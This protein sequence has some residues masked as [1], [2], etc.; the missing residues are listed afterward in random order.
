VTGAS[1]GWRREVKP[2]G[3]EDARFCFSTLLCAFVV[4]NLPRS[5]ADEFVAWLSPEKALKISRMVL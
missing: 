5:C 3:Q 1:S 2:P 4:K